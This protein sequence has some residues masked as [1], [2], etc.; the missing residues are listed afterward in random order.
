VLV[1]IAASYPS[2]EIPLPQDRAA[3]RFFSFPFAV[4]CRPSHSCGVEATD[5]DRAMHEMVSSLLGPDRATDRQSPALDFVKEAGRLTDDFVLVED[6]GL[7]FSYTMR[8]YFLGWLKYLGDIPNISRFDQ[9]SPWLSTRIG[10]VALTAQIGAWRLGSRLLGA[11]ISPFEA[12]KSISIGRSGQR[13]LLRAMMWPE[14]IRPW[15]GSGAEQRLQ[16]L[17]SKKSTS[18]GNERL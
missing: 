13:D 12:V 6:M 16:L 2:G 14:T 3:R 4:K 1:S 18:E 9:A 8:I 10:S 17:Q 7:I 15:G 5:H 11:T